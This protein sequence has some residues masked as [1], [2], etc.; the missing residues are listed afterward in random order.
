M[1]GMDY[2]RDKGIP[3][4]F[5]A[6]VTR[7]NVDTIISESF[8][9]M[10]IRKGCLI[11]WHFLYIPEGRNPDISLMP[12]PEQRELLR[13]KGAQYMRKKK[14]ILIID[15]WN[16]APVVGGCIAGGRY[17]FHINA[18]GDVEPCIFVHLAVDNIKNKS[19]KE[20]INSSFFR[21]IRSHQPFSNNFLRPCM[22]IDHPQVLRDIFDEFKPNPTDNETCGF[23]TTLSDELDKYSQEAA[24]VLDLVWEREILMKSEETKGTTPSST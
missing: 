6:M 21:S 2:L 9:D 22:I 14:P 7:H 4:G 18:K 24:K 1:Q 19:L 12:T 8:N 3:F 11:G 16:D 15:F 13:R 10:L 5:S 17:Y 23:V 20:A